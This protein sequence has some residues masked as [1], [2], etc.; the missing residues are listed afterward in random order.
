MR[1]DG[2]REHVSAILCLCTAGPRHGRS[3]SRR[4]ACARGDA[5]A[6]LPDDLLNILEGNIGPLSYIPQTVPFPTQDL[7]ATFFD[8]VG[9]HGKVITVSEHS[10]RAFMYKNFLTPEECDHL[11]D[12][13]RPIH[14]YGPFICLANYL[15]LR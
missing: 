4:C 1:K 12:R 6:T 14:L 10:P 7:T 15:L 11:I 3:R 9:W 5:R 13:V 2:P 8:K